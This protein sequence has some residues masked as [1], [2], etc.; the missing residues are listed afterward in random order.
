MSH[1]SMAAP[2]HF[3]ISDE[4]VSPD[5]PNIAT[6]ISS[7]EGTIG[8]LYIWARPETDKKLR[9]I[10]LKLVALQAGI[11]FIDSSIAVF[12]DAGG[13]VQR[14]EYT[15]DA[16]STPPIVSKKTFFQVDTLGQADSI[17]S[18][19]GFSL[20]ASSASFKGVGN[21]CV[22]A[23]TGCVLAGDGLP[24]WLIASVDYN[25]I[26]GGPVTSVHLQVGEHGI[27]HESLVS[28]DYDL[29]GVVN[30]DDFN[31]VQ[32]NFSSTSNLWPDGN[33]NGRI[34]AADYTIWQDNLGLVSVSEAGSLTSV[35]FGADT[36]D[37]VDEPIYNAATDRQVTLAMDDPDATITM[38]SPLQALQVSVPEPTS[39]SLLLLSQLFSRVIFSRR[40]PLH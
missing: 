37:G 5:G 18:L 20:S 31:E 23:E 29:N 19:Q 24:A 9:N 36:T 8:T 35:R 15:S 2:A 6:N 39:L 38:V 1:Q 26:V 21:Q 17:K 16:S 30:T 34:D 14:Y 3:W 13:G 7:D 25:A 40:A 28:G 27:Q 33:G 4:G 11:D 22:G 32:T 12:N 10:S